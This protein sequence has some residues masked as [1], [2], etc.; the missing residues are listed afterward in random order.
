MIKYTEKG[1]GL[2]NAITAA[3]HSLYE[4]DGVWVS[5]DD[6]AVQAVIDTYPLS[7]AQDEVVAA[8]AGHAKA[9]RDQVVAGVSPGEMAAWTLKRMEAL[10]YQRSRLVTDAPLLTREATARGASIDTLAA[11]VLSNATTLTNLEADIAG[12]AGKHKDAVRAL[13]TFEA[14]LAYDWSVG[15]PAVLFN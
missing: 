9:L 6:V 7:G 1:V 13:T 12:T 11:K 3:G 5:S 4:L 14:I 2:H 10:T 8:I 15:W